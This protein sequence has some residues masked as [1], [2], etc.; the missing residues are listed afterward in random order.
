M[1]QLNADE[2]RH[3]VDLE[4]DYPQNNYYDNLVLNFVDERANLLTFTFFNYRT[5]IKV[6]V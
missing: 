5:T 4:L 2:T 3:H 6:G 1:H